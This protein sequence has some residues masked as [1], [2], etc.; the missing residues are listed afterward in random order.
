MKDWLCPACGYKARDE[1]DRRNHLKE[2]ADEPKHK[3]QRK[4]NLSKNK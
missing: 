2:T 4:K 3:D 1:K